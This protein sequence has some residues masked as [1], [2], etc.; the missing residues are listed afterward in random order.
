MDEQPFNSKVMKEEL[1]NLVNEEVLKTKMEIVNA[2]KNNINED[3]TDGTKPKPTEDKSTVN[4]IKIEDLPPPPPPPRINDEYHQNKSTAAAEF[5]TN[6]EFNWNHNEWG[7]NNE[8]KPFYD[9]NHPGK[10]ID[11]YEDEE[12]F[13]SYAK[14][15]IHHEM[16]MDKRRTAAYYHAIMNSKDTFKDKVVLDVGCGTG[17][18][19]C[20]AAKA[21]AKKVY[22]VEASDMYYYAEMI[23]NHNQLAD[24]IQLIKGK[25]EEITFPEYVDI[26]ISEW[27]GSFLIFESMLESVIYARDYLL[28]SDGLLFPSKA[29]IY[30]APVRLDDYFNHKV[31]CWENVFGLDMSPLIPLAKDDAT[32]KSI[33]NY[34]VE[35]SSSVLDKPVTLRYLDLH[36]ITISDLSKTMESYKFKI[37]VGNFH[38]YATW[39]SVYFE[40]L[41][42]EENQNDSESFKQYIINVDG[43]LE[44]KKSEISPFN[45]SPNSFTLTSNTL[46]LS[47]APGDGDTHWKQVLFLFDSVKVVDKPDTQSN[48]TVRV[49]QHGDYRRHWWIEL[50]SSTLSTPSHNFY[51]KYLI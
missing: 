42:K 37:P 6:D 14:I 43:E 48:A 41:D 31:N 11:T 7:S 36:T 47:T 33:R 2:L 21:G 35:K 46:E 10:P 24:K 23:V 12:Y 1:L 16:V 30:M 25:L 9:Y 4:N 28:K 29:S 19:S 39:F 45:L 5:N 44:L 20:F 50:F 40:H 51:Q 8:A 15:S 17:L 26:V 3:S 13:N 32:E 22:A 49:I 34:Y 18:L 27:M 38:G